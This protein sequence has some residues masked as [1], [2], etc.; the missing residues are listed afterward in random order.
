MFKPLIEKNVLKSISL[1]LDAI[2]NP[3]GLTSSICIFSNYTTMIMDQWLELNPQ[4]DQRLQNDP[5]YYCKNLRLIANQQSGEHL[6]KINKR[7]KEEGKKENI[8]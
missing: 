2:K 3:L 7:W 6:Q 1:S 8:K 5:Q 4:R